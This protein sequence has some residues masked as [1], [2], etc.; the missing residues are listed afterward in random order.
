M[1]VQ[2]EDAGLWVRQGAPPLM[3]TPHRHND[4]EVN[5]VVEGW[6]DYQLGGETFRLSQGQI[7]V[8]WAAV[9]HRLLDTST[10]HSFW[11]HIP[12]SSVLAW[13]LEEDDLARLLQ[14]RPLTLPADA[15]P[16]DAR[17]MFA[18]WQTE[19]LQPPTAPIAE[20]EAQGLIRRVL[21]QRQW[22]AE[23]GTRTERAAAAPYA[24]TRV[25]HVA[26]LSRCAT[27]RYKEGASVEQVCREVGLSPS[28]AMT[29][30]RSVMGMTLGKYLTWCRV[31]EAQRLLLTTGLSVAEV[32][33]HAGFGSLSSFY[34]HFT[35]ECGVSPGRYRTAAR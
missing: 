16:Y 25:M 29:S 15:L 18:Q 1:N 20:I 34:S 4:V 31:S 5:F 19:L 21:G 11:I 35:A 12:L 7:A 23:E 17:R 6:L 3:R 32:G 24:Q 13:P 26:A 2:N 30:F 14:M 22:R 10:G 33:A 27:E 9:P 28:Y 8:F